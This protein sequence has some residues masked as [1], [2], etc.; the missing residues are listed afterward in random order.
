MIT[1]L[2]KMG[3]QSTSDKPLI[4]ATQCTVSEIWSSE[5]I[6]SIKLQTTNIMLLGSN[7]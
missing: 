4:I 1:N 2:L 3:V 5:S 7:V 6:G